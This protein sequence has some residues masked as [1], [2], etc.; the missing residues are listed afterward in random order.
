MIKGHN[1]NMFTVVEG[2]LF[3]FA[4][5]GKVLIVPYCGL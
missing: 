5:Y 3:V 4:L 2:R 1:R